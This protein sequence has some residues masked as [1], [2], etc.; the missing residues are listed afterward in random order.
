MKI[1]D[2]SV[3]RVGGMY[4]PPDFPAGNRQA[5]QLDAYPEF[6]V[7]P[8]SGKSEPHLI[9][10]S[11]VQ[12]DTD[13]GVSGI[14]GPIDGYQIDPILR[15]LRPLLVGRDA[16]ATE[17][18]FDLMVRS[19]RH[20]RSGYFMTAVSAVDC[21]LWDLKGKA[22]QQPVYRLLARIIQLRFKR[23]ALCVFMV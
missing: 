15:S 12:I 10:A 18:L 20:G 9:H 16:L 13:E 6:N 14:F 2:I 8:R 1:T 7:D 3:I 17:L 23:A 22:W 5:L 19:D 11:Y 4:T 21:A